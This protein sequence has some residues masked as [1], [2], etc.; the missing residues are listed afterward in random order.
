MTVNL[1]IVG[2]YFQMNVD[3]SPGSTISE[4][5]HAAQTQSLGADQQFSFTTS[6]GGFLSNVTVIHR[7]EA[8]SSN[9]G[10]TYCAGVYSLTD[11]ETV[12]NPQ[13][14]WQYYLFD[15][16]NQR[17]EPRGSELAFLK[18]QTP[19]NAGDQVIWRAVAIFNGP[20][21]FGSAKERTQLLTKA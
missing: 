21:S 14:V 4:V 17:K 11:D 7:V 8:Q 13:L 16:Q 18:N 20:N 1:S 5:M 9:S 15:S 6:P 19:L 3:V 10:N 2:M 12:G